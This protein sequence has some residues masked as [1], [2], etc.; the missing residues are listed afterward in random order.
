MRNMT[1]DE[2]R[3][4]MGR[5]MLLLDWKTQYCE[6]DHTTKRR[7]R[8]QVNPSQVAIGYRIRFLKFKLV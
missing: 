6:N 3:K 2:E 8:I 5:Y 4:Q 7:L 1:A